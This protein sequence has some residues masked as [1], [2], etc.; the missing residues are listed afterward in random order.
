MRLGSGSID[1]SGPV[2]QTGRGPKYANTGIV[3]VSVGSP[4]VLA[5]VVIAVVAYLGLARS[6][7]SSPESHSPSVVAAGQVVGGSCDKPDSGW[8]V[9]DTGKVITASRGTPNVSAQQL[10]TSG[11]PIG[12]TVQGSDRRAAILQGVRV[13]IVSVDAAPASGAVLPK[14]CQ[15][16]PTVRSFIV[17]LDAEQP[18]LTPVDRAQNTVKTRDFPYEVS[19]DDPEQW[20]VDAST[21]RQVEWRLVLSW[22]SGGT[23]GTTVIDNNGQPFRTVGAQHLR[24][25]CPSSSDTWTPPPCGA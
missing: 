13:Q 1:G 14:S 9:P 11:T 23:N 2:K 8:V 18:M 19:D 5:V 7:T 21:T 12:I 24:R 22:S 3:N 15:G 16:D 17:D 6:R 20:F 25:Y 10:V 4:A